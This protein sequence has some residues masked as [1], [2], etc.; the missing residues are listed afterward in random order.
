MYAGDQGTDGSPRAWQ[1]R[2]LNNG[3]PSGTQGRHGGD[4]VADAGS[5]EAAARMQA[6]AAGTAGAS[7]TTPAPPTPNRAAM[8][9]AKRKQ[10]MWDIAQDQII[11]I[12]VEAIANMAS[13]EREEWATAHLP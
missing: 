13:E 6:A 3:D 1:R 5:H 8:A 9:L 4:D 7:G 11:Q 12:T 10:E 2:E